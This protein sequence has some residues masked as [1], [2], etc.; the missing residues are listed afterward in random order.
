MDRYLYLPIEVGS[1]ELASK[2]LIAL[3]AAEHGYANAVN[4]TAST[5]ADA[6]ALIADHWNGGDCVRS[7]QARLRKELD[8]YLADRNK[9]YAS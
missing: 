8:H 1:R 7:Q 6:F 3:V 4:P 5:A 2:S 9:S